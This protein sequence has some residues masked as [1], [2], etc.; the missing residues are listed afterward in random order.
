MSNVDESHDDCKY[1]TT[2]D[3][4]EVLDTTP[5]NAIRID[6]REWRN[7]HPV[8]RECW[9]Q[10]SE[11]SHRPIEREFVTSKRGREE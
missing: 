7:M 6:A 5:I 10:L 2:V 11:W 4:I 1:T 8:E 9:Q 3:G